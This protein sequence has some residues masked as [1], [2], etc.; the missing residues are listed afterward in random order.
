MQKFSETNPLN[1][2]T[3]SQEI[4][5]YSSKSK[6]DFRLD[7]EK[8][9]ARLDINAVI[10]KNDAKNL[11]SEP[12]QNLNYQYGDVHESKAFYENLLVE[13]KA[14]QKLGVQL[15]ASH[16]YIDAPHDK[17]L[18][19]NNPFYT[20]IFVDENNNPVYDFGQRTSSI[21]TNVLS[22]IMVQ[23]R[24]KIGAFNTGFRFQS[25]SLDAAKNGFNK[26]DE[27]NL[28][29]VPV[30]TGSKNQLNYQNWGPFIKHRLPLGDITFSNEVR[31]AQIT[32]PNSTNDKKNQSFVE[33]K[34]GVDVSFGSFSYINVALSRQISSYPMQKLV[35]GY[36]L[37]GFQSIA[38]PNRQILTPTP[39]YTLE[40]LG[41]QKF[42]NIGVLFDPALLY[43]RSQNT[44]RFLFSNEPVII[45]EYDQLRSEYWA[46]SFPFSKSLKKIPLDIILEPEALINQSQNI[47]SVGNAYQ[48]RTTRVLMGLKLNTD[49]KEQWYDFNLYPKYTSFIFENKSLNA[50][51]TLDMVSVNLG[52][53]IDLFNDK[54]LFTPTLRTVAFYGNVDSDFT[55]ISLKIEAPSSKIFWFIMVDNLLNSSDFI[56]ESIYPTYSMLESNSVFERYVK[57]GIE[58]KFK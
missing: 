6:L 2:F 3:E 36:D 9:K 1:S 51:S 32:F 39:E 33:F 4:T 7:K 31:L 44:D 52:L 29:P 53:K 8:L 48:T 56:I 24:S 50:Q 45:T 17:S 11:N 21:A 13:Y 49:F 35:E 37:T 55:N 25:R 34:S 30:F 12:L 46:L 41:A 58:Y 19:H 40:I 54:L 27:N 5:N 43:G 22:E 26:E 57:F 16:S 10:F 38:I 14:N 42:T 20:G 23:Y 15:K 28:V 47:D 18:L